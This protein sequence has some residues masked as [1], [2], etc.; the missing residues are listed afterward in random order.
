MSKKPTKAQ[1][2]LVKK[3]RKQYPMVPLFI[4]SAIVCESGDCGSDPLPPFSFSDCEPEINESQIAAI[5]MTADSDDN[6][7]TDWT[8][9]GEW[10]TRIDNTDTDPNK[11]RKVTVIGDKPL[12]EKT[13]K[14]I[15]GLRKIV[16]NK[17]HTLNFDIDES[18]QIIHDAVRK[19]GKCIKKVRFWY[20]TVSGIAF[21]GN[22]GISGTINID[23]N[24][25]RAEGDL[26]LY[27][28]TLQWQSNEL[29][30][31]CVFP[32]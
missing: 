21:G 9:A 25:S 14:T 4:L 20:V 28:G 5:Y 30:E 26:I 13:E 23:M 19:I 16:T 2:K 7:F 11:I 27:S 6:E 31:R 18:N 3:L 1:K 17:K 32:L 29:E 10:T 24:L 15:S 8:A 12:P 22:E